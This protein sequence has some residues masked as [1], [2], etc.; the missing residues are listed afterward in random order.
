[1]SFTATSA[2]GFRCTL[3]W[4]FASR[5]TINADAKETRLEEERIRTGLMEEVISGNV[6]TRY[7]WG[8][9]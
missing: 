5:A 8:W 2:A 9:R 4:D 1:M 7:S 6:A 3:L